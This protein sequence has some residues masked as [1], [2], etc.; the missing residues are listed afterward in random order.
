MVNILVVDDA[1]AMRMIAMRMLQSL[2]VA[3]SQA[4]NGAVALESCR[5][6][7]PDGILLDWNMPVMDGPAFL[8]ALRATPGGDKPK[9]VFCT[10]EGD[11]DKIVTVLGAGADEFIMKPYDLDILRTKLALVGLL[12]DMVA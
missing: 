7:M 5:A 4:E 10:S 12:T 3:V 9:V 1:R 6:H 8:T 2:G 11:M